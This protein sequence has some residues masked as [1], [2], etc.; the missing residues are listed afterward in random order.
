MPDP[1]PRTG[2]CRRTDVDADLLARLTSGA[3]E[4]RTLVEMLVLDHAAVMRACVPEAGAAAAEAL[5]A[6]SAEGIVARMRAGGA[7]LLA[8]YGPDA[9][10]WVG[11]RSDVVRGWGAYVVGLTPG[12]SLARRLA[13]IR[14]FADD[15]NP[16]VREWAWMAVRPAL[17]DQIE[18]AVASLTRWTS[19]TSPNLRRFASEVTRPRGVWCAHLPRLVRE[20][21]L[22]LP[23]LDALRADRVKYVQDSV[24]NWLNDAGKAQPAWVRQLVAE[25]RT[26]RPI[27]SDRIATRALRN[28]KQ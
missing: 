18:D 16:G 25:W 4:T 1:T 11:H 20:P 2:A 9:T 24:A 6:H 13:A 17:A 3:C 12:L 22:A 14:P 26:G 8:R 5:A 10:R 23:I 27:V 15:P 7:E 19:A 21:T 28:L